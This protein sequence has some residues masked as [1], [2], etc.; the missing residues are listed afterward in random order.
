M[1]SRLDAL[2]LLDQCTG[3]DIWPTA[4]CLKQGVPQA[5]IDDLAD[6]FE[7]SFLRDSDTIYVG[8]RATGHFHGV[9][10]VD[11]AQKLGHHL[12]IDVHRI[13]AMAVS[14]VAIVR[15]IQEA[16]EEE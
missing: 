11:L 13:T 5:W 2:N 7:S 6:A 12:G 3:Q 8:D 1:L 15:A 10:D 4:F 14:R 16:V 9:R